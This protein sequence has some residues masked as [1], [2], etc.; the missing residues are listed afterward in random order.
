MSLEPAD[1]IRARLDDLAADLSKEWGIT[2]E[3]ARWW[4]REQLTGEAEPVREFRVDLNGRS[5]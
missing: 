5:E 3:T 2:K 4:L 1:T